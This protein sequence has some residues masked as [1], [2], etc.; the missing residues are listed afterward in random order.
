MDPQLALWVLAR[1]AGIASYA[2]LCIGM[3]TGLALRTT[4]LD[5]LAE[6]KPIRA[7][8]DF[9]AWIWLP[10]GVAH[11]VGLILDKT[12][13]ISVVDAFVP[14]LASYGQLAIG[15]GTL[16]LDLMVLVVV[17]SWLR[18]R[19]DVNLWRAIHRLSY[20]AFALAFAHSVLAGTD[21]GAPLIAGLSW[22]SAAGLA[23]LTV[24]RLRFGPPRERASR[25]ASHG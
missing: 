16:S 14:F 7:L 13:R 21:F 8:H 5:F 2:A 20:G 3:L 10:F 15:L 1:A 23:Y 18:K 12:A 11:V 9:T 25:P 17:T 19:M 22:A 4:V 24:V 6:K